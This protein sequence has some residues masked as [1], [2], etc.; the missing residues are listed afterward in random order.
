M[1]KSMTGFGKTVCELDTK[2][3]TI[4]VKSLNSKNLD[5]NARIPGLYRE[6]EMQIRNEIA[7]MLVRGKVDFMMY[8]ETTSV[9]TNSRINKPIVLEYFRQLKEINDELGL[10]TEADLMQSIL[11]LPETLDVEREELDAEEWKVIMK[12]IMSALS[13]LDRFRQQEGEALNSDILN[14]VDAIKGL[15]PE[16][17]KFEEERI[18]KV[19]DRINEGLTGLGNDS[20]FDKNRFEQEL[21][22]YIEKLD[23]TEEKVRL[24]NHCAYFREVANQ[25]ISNGKK[26][27][28]V[29]QEMGREINTLG[30]KANHQEIQ[31]IVVQMK[32][33]LEKIKEQLLNVL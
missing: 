21:I 2:K 15:I 16:V 4:E 33:E 28:F 8:A 31:Q 13:D 27:G 14:R 22:Y 6:K 7:K 25:S 26:L 20:G 10:S 17:E 30:S 11:R 9:T 32:D 24:L 19:K 29:A 3:I 18:A 12:S 5:I 1:F 23:V